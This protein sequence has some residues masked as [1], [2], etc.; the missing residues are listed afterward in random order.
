MKMMMINDDIMYEHK[1]FKNQCLKKQL[2][3]QN[4][5]NHYKNL[6]FLNT[7]YH[8]TKIFSVTANSKKIKT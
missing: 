3:F 2:Y 1:V 4:L 6:K 5:S 7:E 8:N